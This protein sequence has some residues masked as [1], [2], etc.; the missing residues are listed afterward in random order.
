MA[1]GANEQKEVLTIMTKRIVLLSCVALAL[2]VG[3]AAEKPR[4]ADAPKLEVQKLDVQGPL[5]LIGRGRLQGELWSN[6]ASSSRPVVFHGIR[7]RITV[8]DLA[9]DLRFRCQ[10]RGRKDRRG[11][12]EKSEAE[13]SETR[14]A[15]GTYRCAGRGRAL[16]SG[17]HFRFQAGA[18]VYGTLIPAAYSGSVQGRFK[19]CRPGTEK[20]RCPMGHGWGKRQRGGDR[21]R[22]TRERPSH[23]DQHPEDEALSADEDEDEAEENAAS[24][25]IDEIAGA[26]DSLSDD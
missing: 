6:S 14:T 8:V 2:P 26:L 20:C 9:G 25:A 15:D 17:S 11:D 19:T 1:G 22:P 16:V 18:A 21:E 5:A 7:G 23:Q 4:P 10:G 24:E 13:N 12:A 3:A